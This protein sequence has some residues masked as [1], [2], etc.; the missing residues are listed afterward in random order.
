MPRYP[1][2]LAKLNP[3]RSAPAPAG[4]R[5]QLLHDLGGAHFHERILG[6]ESQGRT[7]SLLST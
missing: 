3:V 1:P 2:V 5:L 6:Y 7:P 4:V